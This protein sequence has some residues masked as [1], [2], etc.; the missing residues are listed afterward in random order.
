[1]APKDV[2]VDDELHA[3]PAF[4]VDSGAS[5]RVFAF[6]CLPLWGLES[7]PSRP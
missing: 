1:M 3:T 4:V 6:D 5:R 2:D 7:V